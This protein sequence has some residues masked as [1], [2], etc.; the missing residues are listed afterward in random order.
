MDSSIVEQD[1]KSGY[2]DVFCGDLFDC[3]RGCRNS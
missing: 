2:R 1:V 3:N